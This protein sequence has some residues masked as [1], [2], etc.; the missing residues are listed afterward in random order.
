[1]AKRADRRSAPKHRLLRVTASH[2]IGHQICDRM[3]I[4]FDRGLINV[5]DW[6]A[7]TRKLIA[8]VSACDTAHIDR[9]CGALSQVPRGAGKRAGR[10]AKGV[11]K[12]FQE[13]TM[14]PRLKLSLIALA[15]ADS[16]HTRRAQILFACVTHHGG[17][18]QLDGETSSNDSTST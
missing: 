13:I 16:L 9:T 4:R 8:S 6:L 11:P 2:P 10:G 15:S 7:H 1:M 3:Y 17:R 18:C 14:N 12:Q 5:M